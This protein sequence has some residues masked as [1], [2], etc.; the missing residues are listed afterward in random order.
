[1]RVVRRQFPVLPAYAKTIN[2]EQ[3]QEEEVLGLDLR[4]DVFS[5]G[6]LYVAVGRPRAK[7]RY[8]AHHAAPRVRRPRARRQC[9]V[10]R[11]A[12]NGRSALAVVRGERAR[13][14]GAPADT[15]TDNDRRKGRHH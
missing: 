15:A 6:Q 12:T 1:M 14:T 11:A 2:K 4:D 7:R 5:H 8:G 9:R 3:G 10:S 13:S